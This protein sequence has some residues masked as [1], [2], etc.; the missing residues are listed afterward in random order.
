VII[1]AIGLALI[2]FG[3]ALG[4]TMVMLP[5]GALVGLIGAGMLVAG[6]VGELPLP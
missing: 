4:V 2:V 3:L 1:A 6:A 5:V